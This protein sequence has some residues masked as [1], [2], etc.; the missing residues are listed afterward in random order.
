MPIFDSGRLNANLAATRSQS[1]LL[2]A[3]YNEAVLNAVREVAQAGIEL[4]GLS[5]QEAM[6]AGK[7]KAA[8]FAANSATAHYRRGLLD[9]ATARDA[10][11]PVLREQSQAVEI[12]GR[13]IQSTVTLATVLGGGYVAEGGG[14]ARA[15]KND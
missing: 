1:N 9:R 15:T 5:D 8:N 14:N 4:D 13:Q 11:L 2:I 7:L 12:R 3:Q 6:Q 10:M